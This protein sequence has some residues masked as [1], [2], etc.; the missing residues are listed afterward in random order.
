MPWIVS[1]P[2][3][4]DGKTELHKIEADVNDA[5][6]AIPQAKQRNPGNGFDWEKAEVEEV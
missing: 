2:F 4:Y 1:V 5:S 6:N 3:G